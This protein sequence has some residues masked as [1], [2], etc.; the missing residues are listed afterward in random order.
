MLGLVGFFFHAEQDKCIIGI[1]RCHEQ[2]M[3]IPVLSIFSE[4]LKIIIT[5]GV[6]LIA[7]PGVAAGIN[8]FLSHFRFHICCKLAGLLCLHR[9]K[10]KDRKEKKDW[11][12]FHA[13]DFNANVL[14]H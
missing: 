2:G 3:L 8:D 13:H 6:I 5:P 1:Y 4:W 11:Y 10:G 9:T 7:I 12:F 14:I